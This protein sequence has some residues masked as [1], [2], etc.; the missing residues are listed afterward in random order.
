MPATSAITPSLGMGTGW[1]GFRPVGYP[2]AGVPFINTPGYFDVVRNTTLGVYGAGGAGWGWSCVNGCQGVKDDRVAVT[3]VIY[4]QPFGLKAEWN[5]GRGPALD[6]TQTYISSRR[7]NGGYVE[8]TYK[9]DDTMFGL[10]TFFPFVK[11]QYFNGGW[12]TQ[13]NSPM[14]KV[15]ELDIG[16]EWQPLPEVEVTATYTRMRRTNVAAA[17][18]RQF[19]ADLLRMQLQWNY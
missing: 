2:G 4:P 19:N 11:W 18:Y 3:G 9:Y 16:V 10:G 17:P 15:H 7:L 12:K 5:W 13:T 8:A 6:E 14:A 1:A